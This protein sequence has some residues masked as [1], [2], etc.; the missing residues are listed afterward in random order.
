MNVDRILETMNTH[1]VSAIL[2]G[3]MNFLLRH[4]PILTYDVDLWVEDT[5]AN[6][7]RCEQAL[8]AL[9]AEWGS[10][11]A[12]WG[13]VGQRDPGW[14]S[15][16]VLFCLSSPHGA[17]DIFRQVKGLPS[18]KASFESTVCGTTAAG[19]P[20]RGL[21]D[22][23]MVRSQ[24]ALEEGERKEDRIAVLRKALGEASDD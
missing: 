6:L 23:D 2:I 1:G 22:A 21:S 12:D 14:L 7:R 15:R 20:Y 19:T 11:D 13:P 8:G 4:R 24:L 16:Q 9:D 18:W 5:E 10:T 3:G 17:I